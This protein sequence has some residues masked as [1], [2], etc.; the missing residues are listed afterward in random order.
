MPMLR[1]LQLLKFFVIFFSADSRV[2]VMHQIQKEAKL[3]GIK[4]PA[5][6]ENLDQKTGMPKI[7]AISQ[8]KFLQIWQIIINV[9]V[10]ATS[11][12]DCQ[13]AIIDEIIRQA[14]PLNAQI[15]RN[16]FCQQTDK[17]SKST[18]IQQTTNITA[19]TF[20][21]SLSPIGGLLLDNNSV[22]TELNLL[23]QSD[24]TS[25][26]LMADESEQTKLINDYNLNETGIQTNINVGLNL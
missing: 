12:L 22:Q 16:D 6:F 4:I 24:Q 21:R 14:E 23:D 3:N 26:V 10:Q 9:L 19:T 7:L 20:D 13:S 25:L 2:G 11:N 15:I 5:I 1:F 18:Q 8:V 17:I